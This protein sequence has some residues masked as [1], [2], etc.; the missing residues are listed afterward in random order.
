MAEA[1]A[2]SVSRQR[3]CLLITKG[4]DRGRGMVSE[5]GVDGGSRLKE[6]IDSNLLKYLLS[7]P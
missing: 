4:L 7:S 5:K 1:A 3:F 6:G 2:L